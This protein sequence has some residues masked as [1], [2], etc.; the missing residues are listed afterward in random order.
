MQANHKELLLRINRFA[1]GD[2]SETS[3]DRQMLVPMLLHCADLHAPTLEPPISRRIAEA[4][5]REQAAQAE[6][7]RR[8]GQPVTVMLANTT[9]NR[10]ALEI[11]FIRFVV[12]PC[13][14]TLAKIAPDLELFVDRIDRNV[15]MWEELKEAGAAAAP[16]AASKEAK[17]EAAAPGPNGAGGSAAGA[18][19]RTPSVRGGL[20]SP[21]TKKVV[22]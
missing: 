8:A 22:I 19:T 6:L 7:E 4:L 10:A 11:S 18:Q 5:G 16:A 14:E 12:R 1:G 17:A 15:E 21:Q 3:D 9:A 2:A 13:W 20:I